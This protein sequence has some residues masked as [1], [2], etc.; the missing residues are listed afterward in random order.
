VP[1]RVIFNGEPGTRWV[2]D[3]SKVQFQFVASLRNTCGACLQ[4]HLAIGPYWP[5]PIHP[6]CRCRQVPVAVGTDAPH[7][8][9]D[10]QKVLARM[11]HDQQVKAIGAANYKLLQAG[12]VSWREIVTQFRVRTLR[13][14]IALNK[15]SVAS[16]LKAGV[17]K[18]VIESAHAAVHTPE[19]ELVR[20]HQ[21]ELLDQLRARG[22][23]Q[24]QLVHELSRG[25]VSRAPIV[26]TTA[27]QSMAGFA[28]EIT[29]AAGL[30]AA[31]GAWRPKPKPPRMPPASEPAAPT[32]PESI[33]TQAGPEIEMIPKEVRPAALGQMVF[34]PAKHDAQLEKA[35]ALRP[36]AQLVDLPITQEL[37]DY[38]MQRLDNWTKGHFRSKLTAVREALAS[39]R[40]APALIGKVGEKA[41]PIV[42]VERVVA[43]VLRGRPSVQAYVYGDA[44]PG[45]PPAVVRPPPAPVKPPPAPVKPPPAPVK[46]PPVP[47][48]PPPAPVKPGL[49]KPSAALVKPRP[50]PAPRPSPTPATSALANRGEPIANR[51]ATAQARAKASE[52]ADI[53]RGP[54]PRPAVDAAYE[55]L[56]SVVASE[57]AAGTTASKVAIEQSARD[58][59]IAKGKASKTGAQVAK[60]VEKI[61]DQPKENR[62][63]WNHKDGRG[64]WGGALGNERKKALDWLESKLARAGV[65]PRS[66]SRGRPIPA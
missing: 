30:A 61:L 12:V 1:A 56:K 47:V 34:D 57:P 6:N 7:P 54:D 52:I 17:K 11:P 27:T 59:K 14:V 20:R 51:L 8:F 44:G 43:S 19:A 41:T 29:H 65:L 16:A 9:V 39:D 40:L 50:Q 4:Y 32:V 55:Q 18:S 64:P 58:L 15:V 63:A 3:T 28:A 21:A 31:L 37:C 36:S 46:P 13:E 5:I 62:C 2:N 66:R 25:I 35:L 60:E 33:Q 26:G 42:G 23:S 38:A 24:Q 53:T 49:V 48:K 45:P 22:V 10:F